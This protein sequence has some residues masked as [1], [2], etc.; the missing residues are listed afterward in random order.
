MGKWN[1]LA[2]AKSKLSETIREL[3]GYDPFADAGDCTFD[4]EAATTAILYWEG[5]LKHVKGPLAGQPYLLE[6]HEKAI[7]ANIFGWK[8]PDGMRRFRHVFYFVPRGNSKSTFAA[9]LMVLITAFEEEAGAENYST[10]Y[11]REQ[12]A[13]VFDIA[14]RMVRANPLLDALAKVY[15]NAIVF[16]DRS[17]KPLSAEKNS[18]HGLN[19]HLVVNDELH[20]HKT[21]EFIDV[22][23]TGLGKRAQPLRVDITTADY[24]REGSICNETYDFA[25]RVRDG[26]LSAPHFLPVVYEVSP[27]EIDAEPE[28]WRDPEK[29]AKANPLL[30]KAIPKEYFEERFQQATDSPAFENTF[31]RL[32][33]NIRTENEE[34]LL[35]MQNWVEKCGG[36]VD[37]EQYKGKQAAGVGLDLGS[38]SDL[39]SACLLFDRQG[40]PEGEHEYDALW[41][42][43]TPIAKAEERQRKDQG[44]NYTTWGRAGWLELTEGDET[45][46]R[47]IR[48][49][50][51]EIGGEYGI[52]A[53]HVDRL[54]QGAQLCQDLADDGFT[55]EEFGQGFLSMAAPTAEFVKLVNKGHLHHGDSPLMRWQAANVQAKMDAAGN[56]KPDKAKSGNK[57]DG[58]VACVM[59]LAMAI[60]RE[61]PPESM[62]EK[63]GGIIYV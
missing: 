19:I 8:R 10:G 26:E 11:T 16:R 51:N 6:P 48:Q 12:A 49:R 13:L 14:D 59:A 39:T 4:E 25:C 55:I 54:F 17:Y 36:A 53:L 45:D 34:R 63:H 3:P 46:Y 60:G 24:L 15:K 32:H 56:I 38:T 7:V 31:K 1:T 47:H 41:F 9:G 35:D 52:P 50:L 58:I 42:H 23:A 27:K 20:T 21:R 5:S 22:I 57:I 2:I 28:C 29:W 61:N 37:F 30:Y 40:T 62:I 33:L 43:W 18:A 44:A